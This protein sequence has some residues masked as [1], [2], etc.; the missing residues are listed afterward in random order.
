[1]SSALW[2]KFELKALD[3]ALRMKSEAVPKGPVP[4]FIP[5]SA[6]QKG[7]LEDKDVYERTLRQAEERSAHLEREAYDKGFSQ[8]EK[9]GFEL[10][11]KKAEKTVVNLERLFEELRAL[12]RELMRSQEKEIVDV[13]FAIAR[14]I[15]GDQGLRD[16]S[17]VQRTVLNALHLAADRSEVS[18]RIHPDDAQ[19]IERIKP[20]FFAKF[21]EL[22]HLAVIPD[23]GV[24]RGGCLMEN[25]CGEVDGRIETQLEEIYQVMDEAFKEH[26]P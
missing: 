19:L 6:E 2:A 3:R 4:E 7:F 8:G 13:V 16:E 17:L 21:K 24:T 12:K 25:S 26:T 5:F 14:K 22:K 18:L 1:M 11:L 23:P 9:D 15:V 20:A 10:G